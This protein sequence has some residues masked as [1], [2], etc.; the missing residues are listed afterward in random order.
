MVKA[1]K[2]GSF[3][4]GVVREDL[5]S[6]VCVAVINPKLRGGVI[7]K[8]IEAAVEDARKKLVSGEAR[9]PDENN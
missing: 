8:D 6:G 3:K 4:G 1:V 7:T 2:D 9:I 5:A